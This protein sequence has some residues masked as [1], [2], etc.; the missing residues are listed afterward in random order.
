LR[1]PEALLLVDD[2][3]SQVFETHPAG[4]DPVG[5]DDDVD[6]AVGQPRPDPLGLVV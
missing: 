4:E 1:H 6:G 2:Q 5:G 3:Q